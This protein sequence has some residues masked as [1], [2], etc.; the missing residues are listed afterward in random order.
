MK[1]PPL[2]LKLPPPPPM[3]YYPGCQVKSWEPIQQLP[4][5]PRSLVISM[6]VLTVSSDQYDCCY[7]EGRGSGGARGPEPSRP[8]QVQLA[9]KPHIVGCKNIQLKCL[10]ME[11]IWTLYQ[12]N[13]ALTSEWFSK[14]IHLQKL[15]GVEFRPYASGHI[16]HLWGLTLINLVSRSKVNLLLFRNMHF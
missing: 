5:P 8:P 16:R 1:V 11:R 9:S 7:V 12:K 10:S 3:R 6:W 14:D 2:P 4:C 13:I 15:F